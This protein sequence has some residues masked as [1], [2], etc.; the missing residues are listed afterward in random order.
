MFMRGGVACG[1]ASDGNKDVGRRTPVLNRFAAFVSTVRLR[2]GGVM[3]ACPVDGGVVD[4]VS[5]DAGAVVAPAL[6]S[7][8][9]R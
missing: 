2:A 1:A 6:E 5:V 4:A 7:L 3:G 8:A 9:A